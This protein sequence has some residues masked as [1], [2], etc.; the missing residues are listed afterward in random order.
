MSIIHHVC[1]SVGKKVAVAAMA[2]ALAVGA[3]ISA[4]ADT[5]TATGSGS[6]SASVPING[7]IN[8][9]TICVTVPNSVSYMINPDTNTFTAPSLSV[10]NNTV[11][12]VTVGV[13]SLTADSSGTVA[14]VLPGDMDWS[15]L[16]A[17]NSPKYLALGVGVSDPSGWDSGYNT[18]TDWAASHSSVE[19][20]SLAAGATGNLAL[21]AN[22]GRAFQDTRTPTGAITFSVSLQGSFIPE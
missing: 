12:P 20:G 19:I 15:K 9:T 8:A 18:N 6:A 21:S 7:T 5:A 17:A 22:F 4:L 14:D 11:V 2:A 1:R 3:S 10:T 13:Q 16:T